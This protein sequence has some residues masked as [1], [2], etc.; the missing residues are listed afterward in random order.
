MTPEDHPPREERGAIAYMAKNGVA[1]NLLMA[2]LLLMGLVS[3]PGLVEEGFPSLSFDAVEVSVPWPGATPSEVDDSIVS[4]VE[5]A[6]S[7]VDQVWEVSSIAA[8]GVASVIVEVDADGDMQRALDDIESAVSGIEGLPA[9]SERPRVREMTNRQSA[10]RLV[11]HGDVPERI[12]KTLA[13]RVE[14]SLTALPEVSFVTVAGI[15]DDE[16]S[17]EVPRARLRALGLTLADLAGA[18]RAGSLEASA[19]AMDTSDARLRVRTLGRSLT[20][21]EFED[22]VVL[23]RSDGTVVR[24]GDIAEVRDGFKDVDMVARYNG[25]PAAFVEVWRTSDESVLEIAAVVLSHVDEVRASLPP[26]VSISVL[27]NDALS[28][29]ERLNLLLKNGA[30]GLMLVVLALGLFLEIRLAFWA[31]VGIL[32]SGIGA[33]AALLLAG[34]SLNI[35]SLFAFVLAIGVVVDDAIVVSESIYRER[36]RGLPGATAAIRGA[37]R[38]RTPVIFAVLTSV[39]AFFPMIFMPTGIGD[40][41][42]AVPVI[43]I[44]MLLISLVESL[45]VLPNHLSHLPDPG[46]TVTNRLESAVLRVQRGAD[47]RLAWFRDGPLNAALEAVTRQPTVALATAVGV[48]IVTIGLIPAGVINI[49]L[50]P[51]ATGDIV[52]ARLEMPEGTPAATT[53]A[54]AEELDAAG[55]R[56]LRALNEGRPS[57]LVGTVITLGVPTRA[58]G[59]GVQRE[60]SV[61][62]QS[63]IA[64]VEIKLVNVEQR[65]MNADELA[66]RWREEA[67]PLPQATGLTFSSELMELGRPVEIAISHPDPDR[68]API[69]DGVVAG[70]NSL[71]GVFDIRSDHVGGYQEV[72]LALKP[73]AR[74]L[75]LTLGDLSSQLRSMVYGEEALRVPRDREDVPVLARLPEAERDAIA[76]IENFLVQAPGGAVV[77]LERVA[78]LGVDQGPAT[79]RRRDGERIVTVSAD[80]DF[81]VVSGAAVIEALEGGA[82][83]DVLERDPDLRWSVAGQQEQQAESFGAL[84][85]G[86]MMALLVIYALLAIPLGS[87]TKPLIV[88]AAIPFGIVGAIL[89]HLVLGL[90]LDT[91]SITAMLGLTGIVVNDSLVMIDAVNRRLKAGE[92]PRTAIVEGAKSRFRPILLTSITTFLAFVPL[93]LEPSI[94]AQFLVAYAAS[95]GFGVLFATFVLMLIVP[96]LTSVQLRASRG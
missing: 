66:R 95:I 55:R 23:S 24:L 71:E 33:L 86:F 18:V 37:L 65:E 47:R 10:V 49:R 28:Y 25:E 87:Y 38:V 61:N 81:A 93:L 50:A 17:I 75:G 5:E 70:L 88:M 58:P 44:A 73:E 46:R 22:V 31:S 12:L 76:D 91:T 67:G 56:A 4:R 59:G 3:C 29:R 21:Q 35:I 7:G 13:L 2:A 77:P 52:S 16:I 92:A 68:L 8:E 39:A 78:S 64:A 89:G 57:E 30:L 45:L 96:A 14:D 74:T 72:Q 27:N 53:L 94:Q 48:S 1:A 36:R 26:G 42:S 15:R 41:L 82:L 84:N 40:I 32:V 69:G 43:M 60:P 85:R 63:H 20:Q 79:I 6:V 11:L 90:D 62:P 83:A 19:G 34:H 51:P 80:V 9:D 54:I